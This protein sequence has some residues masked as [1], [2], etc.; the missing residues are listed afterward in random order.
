[1][2]AVASESPVDF[3]ENLPLPCRSIGSDLLTDFNLAGKT[4]ESY[5]RAFSDVRRLLEE[6]AF[7]DLSPAR[8]G[9][10]LAAIFGDLTLI[11]TTARDQ[12]APALRQMT[13]AMCELVRD[14]HSLSVSHGAARRMIA[15]CKLQQHLALRAALFLQEYSHDSAACRDSVAAGKA[16]TDACLLAKILRDDSEIRKEIHS[17][18]LR[19]AFLDLL[20]SDFSEEPANDL[21]F[22]LSAEVFLLGCA[23]LSDRITAA[24]GCGRTAKE[25]AKG[26]TWLM[27]TGFMRFNEV[28]HISDPYLRSRAETLALEVYEVAGPV[29]IYAVT[30]ACDSATES[31]MLH[32]LRCCLCDK[33]NT[34]HAKEGNIDDAIAC[35]AEILTL[36]CDGWQ[37]EAQVGSKATRT[38]IRLAANAIFIFADSI[39]EPRPDDAEKFAGA[40]SNHASAL[41]CTLNAADED[42]HE[43]LT[44]LARYQ[45]YFIV[46]ASGS[47]N[48]DKFAR[49]LEC[50]ERKT[51]PEEAA[52]SHSTAE[53]WRHYGRA[54]FELWLRGEVSA[55]DLALS[56]TQQK[57]AAFIRKGVAGSARIAHQ[58][59]LA[60]A[61][62]RPAITAN[63]IMRCRREIETFL[64]HK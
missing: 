53:A 38:P 33:I 12:G 8:A 63:A 15:N 29:L 14:T 28:E 56:P 17:I 31:Q 11:Y 35:A 64:S 62:R 24:D 54:L 21:R 43:R 22:I 32:H 48:L 41:L 5:E 26:A 47:E 37:P 27:S 44:C 49:A 6:P 2:V 61:H 30:T 58:D 42:F 57:A 9:R 19:T 4:P 25:S 10:I 60:N 46:L 18:G 39:E 45:A 36:A 51:G 3:L 1:M 40:I 23:L 34:A 50:V 59:Y 16:L 7:Q 55:D 20:N 13:D 52:I